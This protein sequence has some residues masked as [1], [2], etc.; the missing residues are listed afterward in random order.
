MIGD[1]Q[2]AGWDYLGEGG[3]GAVGYESRGGANQDYPYLTS[4]SGVIDITG[5][6]RP[7]VGLNQAVWGLSRTPVIGVEPLTHAGEKRIYPMWRKSDAVSSW[8]WAGCEGKT[9]EILVYSDSHSAE[10][11]LNGKTLGKKKVKACAA[12]FKATYEKGE[13]LAVV[14]N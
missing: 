1:F 8:S 12:K 5:H 2:W 4:D 10:L 3:L 14:L 11:S 9:A 7:E 6:A 13:L